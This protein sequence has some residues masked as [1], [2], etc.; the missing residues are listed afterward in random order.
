MRTKGAPWY[1]VTLGT[2]TTPPWALGVGGYLQGPDILGAG[3]HRT[4]HLGAGDQAGGSE[5][6]EAAGKETEE[7]LGPGE[8]AWRA[9]AV[10][11]SQPHPDYTSLLPGS[12]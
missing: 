11:P 5:E 3:V 10:P 12:L 1:Y 9:V 7:A 2:G 6:A 8:E 4:S